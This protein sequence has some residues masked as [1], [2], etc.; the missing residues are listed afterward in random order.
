VPA[1]DAVSPLHDRMPAVMPAEDFAAWLDPRPH[2]PAKLLRLLRPCPA[3]RVRCWPVGRRANSARAVDEPGLT[4]AVELP[5]RPR[6]LT[7]S[8]AA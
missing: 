2:D 5:D 3:E 6:Q 8:D 4:A 1:N 7:Q